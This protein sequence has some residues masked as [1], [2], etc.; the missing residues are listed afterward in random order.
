[1]NDNA[2]RDR[3]CAQSRAETPTCTACAP[4]NTH[5]KKQV[6]LH[7]GLRMQCLT[8]MLRWQPTHRLGHKLAA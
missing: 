4:A 7:G 5:P 1:M 3:R 2:S 6:I 8:L